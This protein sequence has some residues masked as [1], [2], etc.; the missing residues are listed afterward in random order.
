MIRVG[1]KEMA[2]EREHGMDAL[3]KDFTGN[4]LGHRSICQFHSSMAV[5]LHKLVR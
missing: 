2:G 4:H 3:A 5:D 1:R